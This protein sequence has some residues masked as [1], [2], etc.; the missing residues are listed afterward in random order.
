MCALCVYVCESMSATAQFYWPPRRMSI[1]FISNTS[2][3][4][5]SNWNKSFAFSIVFFLFIKFFAI[6]IVKWW[7]YTNLWQHTHRENYAYNAYKL[8]F[9]RPMQCGGDGGGG[10]VLKRLCKHLIKYIVCENSRWNILLKLLLIACIE[11]TRCS[12]A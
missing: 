8:Q 7:R 1:E 5:Y 9:S 6:N 11:N 2:I 12:R 4:L 3:K 10:M